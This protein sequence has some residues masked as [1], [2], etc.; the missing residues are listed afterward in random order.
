MKCSECEKLIYLFH[1]LNDAERR[2]LE[3]HL[4][5]CNACTKLFARIQR[6]QDSVKAVLKPVPENFENENPFLTAKIIAAIQNKHVRTES[7]IERFLP[8]MRFNVLRYSMA[9]I[10]AILLVFFVTEVQPRQQV[11]SAIEYYKRTPITKKVQLNSVAFRERFRNSIKTNRPEL[12]ASFSVSDCLKKCR[13][14]AA[15]DTCKECEKLLN[16]IKNEGI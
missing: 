15:D 9:I 4:L 13:G 5:E 16:Q 14:N 3:E 1:E 7:M 12:A 6:E 2:A 8:F 11:A 10:S